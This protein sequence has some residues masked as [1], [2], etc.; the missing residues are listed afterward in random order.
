VSAALAVH[1]LRL[2]IGGAVIL[3]GI[4]LTV[5]GGE[6]LGV[7]G[8]NG[9]GK[10]T[11]FNVLSGIVAPSVG[12]V[13]L[14]GVEITAASPDRRA[15]SGLG[16]SFQTSSLFAK[17]PVLENV[18]IAAESAGGHRLGVRA[19]VTRPRPDDAATTA[20][21]ELLAR[22]GLQGRAA[23]PAAALSHGEQRKLEIAML[24]A[25]QARVL[26]LDEPMAGVA[27]GDVDEL[28]ELIRAVHR[29]TGCTLLM[30]EHHMPVVLGLAQRVAVLH[31]GRLL[32][33]A[34]P[35]AVMADPEVQ[36]AYL[37]RSA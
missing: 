37:G 16:R 27:A 15:R 24:L 22:V 21:R 35:E 32:A 23:V 20:A 25:S 29:D 30:V 2:S 13:E 36:A 6:L 26:L 9:A 12:R 19:L 14:D 10:T 18:R 8:P 1:E 3:D 31:H 11:L 7:I 5:P 34:A 28:V 33:C 17:L 4:E